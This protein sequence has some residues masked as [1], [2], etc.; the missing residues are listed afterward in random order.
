MAKI[1]S[2][3]SSTS[4]EASKYYG[5][6]TAR[7]QPDGE[8]VPTAYCSSIHAK[9]LCISVFVLV[10]NILERLY[11]SLRQVHCGFRMDVC[12]PRLHHIVADAIGASDKLVF[13]AGRVV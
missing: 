12:V 2:E 8:V 6:Q 3:K 7:G 4:R 1:K 13:R 9:A 5:G 10:P 11:E